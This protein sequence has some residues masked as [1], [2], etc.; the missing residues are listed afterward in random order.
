MKGKQYYDVFVT[1]ENCNSSVALLANSFVLAV[2]SVVGLLNQANY[3]QAK[4]HSRSTQLRNCR[5]LER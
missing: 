4:Q 3:S 5:A 1:K 2:S